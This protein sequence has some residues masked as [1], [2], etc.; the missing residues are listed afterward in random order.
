MS[1]LVQMILSGAGDIGT[2]V[3]LPIIVALYKMF[4]NHTKENNKW[5]KEI[6]E[7]INTLKGNDLGIIRAKLKEQSGDYLSK[8]SVT[9]EELSVMDSLFDSYTKLGG[10]SFIKTAVKKV[11]ELPLRTDKE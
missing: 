2:V 9:Y 4:E 8:G 5:R 6:T 1:E 3:A 7:A 10:N 11:H